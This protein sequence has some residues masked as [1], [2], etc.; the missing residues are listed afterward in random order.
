MRIVILTETFAKDMSYLGSMLPKYLAKFGAEV[1]VLSLD[2]FPYYSIS[3]FDATYSHFSASNS[4]EPGSAESI[5]DY[6]LHILRHKKCLGYVYMP[7][8]WKKLNVLQPDVVYSLTAIGWLPLQAA[9]AKLF[10]KFKLFTGSHITASTFPLARQNNY[11][12]QPQYIKCLLMRYI[13]GRFVSLVTEKCY[14]PTIDSAEIAWRFFG[15]QQKKVEVL[16]LG[17]D[18]DYFFPVQSDIEETKRHE[19]RRKLG[20]DDKDIVCIYTGKMTE[21][22]N[23]LILAKAVN[24]LK[25]NGYDF[26][27]LFIGNGVQKTEIEQFDTS[28]VLDFM[29]YQQLGSY[30]RAA[31]IGV[32]PTNES[33]SMLDA[34]ACGLPLIV[35]D[36]IVYREHVDGNGLVYEMNDVESLI[37]TLIMLRK[38]EFRKMLGDA[39]AKKM[40]N[41]FSWEEIAKRR[42]VD[43]EAALK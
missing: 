41:E 22:K 9:I 10:L 18:T 42:L 5:L 36:G 31:D 35:S 4:P 32:W 38:L 37:N 15:V 6:T 26:K 30:Y 21:T 1:H 39:G 40:A 8:L 12:W 13:H 33:T 24:L 25:A 19:L 23:A 2:L 17:V 11:L 43:F 20:F 16:H 34:A 3:D 7:D 28:V 29:P 27:A 14:A